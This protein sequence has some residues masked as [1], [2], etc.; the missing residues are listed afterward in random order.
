M[1]FNLILHYAIR[2]LYNGRHIIG[3]SYQML[4]YVDD[5]VI[6]ARNIGTLLKILEKLER[7]TNKMGLTLNKEK[8]K[9]L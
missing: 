7:K 2:D 8:T 4:A 3:K 6:C 1:V 5:V 9:Y